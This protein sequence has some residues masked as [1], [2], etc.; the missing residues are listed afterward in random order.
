MLIQFGSIITQGAGK[1]GGQIIQR[2]AHGQTMRTLTP[3]KIRRSPASVVPRAT[4]SAVSSAWKN[5]SDSDRASWVALA[6]GLTR[7]NKFGVSYTPS[8]YQIFCE[9]TMNYQY[10]NPETI[11]EPAPTLPTFPAPYN[12]SFVANPTGPSV[13]VTFDN[14]VGDSDF[15]ALAS[16]Y[17]LQ[18]RGA[19]VPRG[20]SRS[21]GVVS[22]MAAGS[23][24]L[25][26]AF[27][28]RFKTVTGGQFQ[29]AVEVKII[30]LSTGFSL[31]S[32]VLMAPYSTP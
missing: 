22:T 8:A 18:S 7:T 30:Q 5:L 1:I 17:P 26:A 32:V 9:L 10:L 28:A 4:V 14:V 29:A 19:T 24:D 31:P 27:T 12:W 2:G 16:F 15:R 21:T 23:L 13:V 11:I 20:S 25:S 6:A 3:P